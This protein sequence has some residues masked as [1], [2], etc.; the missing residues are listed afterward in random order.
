M[1]HRL[2]VVLHSG[3]GARSCGVPCRT[4]GGDVALRGGAIYRHH[5]FRFRKGNR[6]KTAA[7][8]CHAVKIFRRAKRPCRVERITMDVSDHLDAG[9]RLF[10]AR[11]NL[12]AS[13]VQ[14][15]VK[16]SL[17][18]GRQRKGIVFRARRH[19]VFFQNFMRL[20]AAVKRLSR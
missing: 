20:Q 15:T 8:V 4:C 3:S 11:K 6:C 16:I 7:T 18:D 17:G 14:M 9:L 13:T 5:G 19:D 12:I 1:V 10:A 2:P